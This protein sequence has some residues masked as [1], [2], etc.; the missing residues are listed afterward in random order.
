[1]STCGFVF[2][3]KQRKKIEENNFSKSKIFS[4]WYF[5]RQTQRGLDHIIKLKAS[6]EKK[7]LIIRPM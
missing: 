7:S 3:M 5:Y 4:F 1:M 2:K 6:T